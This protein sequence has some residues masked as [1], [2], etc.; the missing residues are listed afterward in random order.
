MSLGE[1]INT[2]T[3]TVYAYLLGEVVGSTERRSVPTEII[4]ISRL[5][6]TPCDEWT[7]RVIQL[8]DSPQSIRIPIEQTL[9]FEV[10]LLTIDANNLHRII[11]DN[12]SEFE[13]LLHQLVLLVA[14]Q[15]LINDSHSEIYKKLHPQML[16]QIYLRGIAKTLSNSCLKLKI[17]KCFKVTRPSLTILNPKGIY[18]KKPHQYRLQV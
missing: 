15:I 8:L 12:Y 4:H 18:S 3:H 11:L 7:L 2:P 6:V 13:L 1:N 9:D 5:I 14:S 10:S 16:T 17:N